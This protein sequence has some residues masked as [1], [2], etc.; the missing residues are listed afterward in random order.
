MELHE[1]L[2]LVKFDKRLLDWHIRQGTITAADVEKH[3]KSLPD[4]SAQ[5]MQIEL[6]SDNNSSDFEQ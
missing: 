1:A 4:S 3:I 5:A 2:Q 6:D